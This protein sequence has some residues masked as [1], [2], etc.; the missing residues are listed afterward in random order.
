MEKEYAVKLQ[1]ELGAEAGNTYIKEFLDQLKE[2]IDNLAISI[3][4]R[5]IA[6]V[7]EKITDEWLRKNYV[8]GGRFSSANVSY[9]NEGT[10]SYIVT[11]YFYGV[12][13][14]TARTFGDQLDLQKRIK[15]RTIG[16][17]DLITNDGYLIPL[18]NQGQEIFELTEKLEEI[19]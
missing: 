9:G 2:K 13:V 16:D 14:Y 15:G 1:L 19:K 3:I 5:Y 10:I 18:D 11:Q 4:D 6:K 12:E 8:K 17:I 7:P